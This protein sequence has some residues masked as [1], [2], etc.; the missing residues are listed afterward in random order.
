YITV[1]SRRSPDFN[2]RHHPYCGLISSMH[3]WGLYNGRYGLSKLVLIDKIPPPDRPLAERMLAHEIDRQKQLK[4]QIVK[5]AQSARW[6]EEDHMFQNYKQLQFFDTLALYFNRTHPSERDAQE[7]EHV[8]LNARQDVSVTLRP[9]AAGVYEVSPYPFAANAGEFAFAGRLVE[10][11][12]SQKACRRPSVLR[13]SP[14]RWE[15]F[16]LVAA[17]VPCAAIALNP[18]SL[19]RAARGKSRRAWRR[20]AIRGN[21]RGSSRRSAWQR[22]EGRWSAR[23]S[24]A[25]AWA[26]C[27]SGCV[28]ISP[29]S[30]TTRRCAARARSCRFCASAPSAPRT[31]A[32]SSATTSSSCTRAGCSGFTSPRPSAGWSLTSWRSWTS[33]R[34]LRAAAR[35]RP[36][37]W[38]TSPA[39]IGFSDITTPRPSAKY[40]MRIRTR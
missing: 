36:G 34:S 9:R 6:I 27:R 3:S 1:T 30:A 23:A 11:P 12:Q 25:R 33:R 32:C 40:G 38:A 28:V 8:P 21:V 29:P 4:A 39:I 31:R 19:W 35:P 26:R 18:R 7:F 15:S 16:S 20:L 14:R 24:K 17:C 10:P 22:A 37:A 2:E 5:D 13:E